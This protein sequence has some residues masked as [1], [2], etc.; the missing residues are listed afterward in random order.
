MQIALYQPDIAQNAGTILRL[1]A[2]MDVPVHIIEPCG[3]PFSIKAFRRSGMDYLDH[4]DVT[5]H[6]DFD[7]FKLWRN[8]SGA[9]LV[10]LTTKA[11][12]PY[13]DC[14]FKSDDILLLGRES[15]GVPDDVHAEVDIRALIPMKEGMRSINVAM[16]A[17]MVLG[18][19]LRQTNTFPKA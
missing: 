12:K 19:S 17:S 1:A 8:E 9:R 14:S 6:V 16:A 11:S 4:V 10:L 2:C 5:R 3:F 15:A 13:T 18:E 7:A